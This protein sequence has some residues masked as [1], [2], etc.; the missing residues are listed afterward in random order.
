[1]DFE[2]II[3]DVSSFGINLYDLALY[4]EGEIKTHRF[5]PCNRC[6]DSY[7][8]AKVFVMTAAGLLFDDNKLRMTDSFR[9]L[10][11][12]YFGANAD[13]AWALV[14]I[15]NAMTHRV[16]FGQATLDIDCEDMRLYPSDDYLAYL[17]SLPLAH[18]PGTER[19]YTDAAFYM[20]SRAV[21]RISG[22]TVDQLLYR[23]LLKPL[24]FGEVAWSRDPKGYPIGATGL[25]ASAEDMVKIGALYLENGVYGGERLLSAEWVSLALDRE[26]ELH[27]MTPG[28]L[29]GKGGMF[30]QGLCFSPEKRF[31]VAWHAHQRGDV[32]KQL[33]AYFD[34]LPE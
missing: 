34:S 18:R 13:P 29:I 31:A 10:F 22:E 3:A 15:E 14:T 33:I 28:G 12:G 17:F 4:R 8:V 11:P 25:Y 19:V 1:M 21:S 30:G 5:I 24:R 6:N 32:A 27:T 2:K 26:Y 9:A 23:R 7:S 16:G 20:L